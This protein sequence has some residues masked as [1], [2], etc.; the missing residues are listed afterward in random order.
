MESGSSNTLID[1]TKWILKWILIIILGLG[2]LSGISFAVYQYTQTTVPMIALECNPT[3]PKFD[4]ADRAKKKSKGRD[5]FKLIDPYADVAKTKKLD[6]LYLVMK[7]RFGDKP[8]GI[9]QSPH[10]HSDFNLNTSETDFRKIGGFSKVDGDNYVFSFSPSSINRKTLLVKHYGEQNWGKCK[11]IS[12]DTFYELVAEKTKN[13][14][15]E[16]KF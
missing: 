10:Y 6:G 3:T 13:L 12:A 11:E 2:V 5:L 8:E 14:K 15:K 16:L 9:Y 4:W 1:F 7:T